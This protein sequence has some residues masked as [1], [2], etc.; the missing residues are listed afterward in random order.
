MPFI[1]LGQ[2]RHT[3]SELANRYKHATTDTTRSKIKSQANMYLIPEDLEK[4][5]K[6]IL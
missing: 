2:K 5:N 4:F 6:Q 3:V 1:K